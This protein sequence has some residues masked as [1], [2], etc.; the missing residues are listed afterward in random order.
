MH[1]APYVSET[2]ART[3]GRI[4]RSWG[5]PAL[6]TAIAARVIDT[7]QG[8]GVV[9]AYYPDQAWLRESEFLNCTG[10]PAPTLATR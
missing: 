1:G 3:N 4:G 8:G 2:L 6:R 7:I 5:C 9:F 10:A